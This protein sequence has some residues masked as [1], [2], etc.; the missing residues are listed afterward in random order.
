M[1]R[2]RLPLRALNNGLFLMRIKLS[3]AMCAYKR[4]LACFIFF[5]YYFHN[6]GDEFYNLQL[7]TLK[8][9]K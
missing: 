4:L 8:S 1:V 9:V 6:Y 5:I 7:A 3:V 2:P